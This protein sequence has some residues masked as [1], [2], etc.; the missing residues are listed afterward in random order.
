ML[1]RQL[2]LDEQSES[3]WPDLSDTALL[4]SLEAWLPTVDTR[5]DTVILVNVLEHIE[6]DAAALDSFH[7]I[8][9]PGGHLLLLIRRKALLH[10]LEQL[11]KTAA[12]I[13]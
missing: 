5:Y 11:Q 6:D 3:E 12:A 1:L 9:T 7:R 8:L 10:E 2:E 13:D 4:D